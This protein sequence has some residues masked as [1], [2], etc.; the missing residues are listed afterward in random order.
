[1]FR[2][3]NLLCLRKPLK[4]QLTLHEFQFLM[5]IEEILTHDEI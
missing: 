4:E 5:S 3:Q 2:K 1:M